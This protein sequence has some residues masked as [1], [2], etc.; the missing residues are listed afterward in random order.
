MTID[1]KRWRGLKSLVVDAV[2]HG[3]MAIERVQKETARRPF[4]ILESIPPIAAPVRG[5]HLVHD[6]SVSGVH[7]IIRLVTR[8]VGGTI[9]IVIDEIERRDAGAGGDPDRR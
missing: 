8:T 5:I 2:E 7:G 3:S 9:D 4:S 1:A 6:A